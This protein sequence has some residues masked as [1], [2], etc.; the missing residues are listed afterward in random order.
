M[1]T[2]CEQSTTKNYYL[3]VPINIPTF[4]YRALLPALDFSKLGRL[5]VV[6]VVRSSVGLWFHAHPCRHPTSARA[7]TGIVE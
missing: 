1:L 5:V 7:A 6:L 3:F 4:T 2:S